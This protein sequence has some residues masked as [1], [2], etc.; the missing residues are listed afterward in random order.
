[1]G[2]FS[3]R[4]ETNHDEQDRQIQDAKREGGRLLNEIRDR[5]GDGTATREDKRI[6]NATQKRGGRIK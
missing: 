3:K 2:I 4:P 1:M 6:F 5:I